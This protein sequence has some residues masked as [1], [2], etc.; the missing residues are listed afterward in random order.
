MDFMKYRI[1]NMEAFK[2]GNVLG[3]KFLKPGEILE[4]SEQDMVKIVNSGGIV[5]VIETM[6]PN[7]KKISQIA[8]EVLEEME[9]K[10]TEAE[11]AKEAEDAQAKEKL[12]RAPVN[13]TPKKRPGR[14]RKVTNAS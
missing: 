2:D 1:K 3:G 4:V 14:P 13:E 8:A 10:K 12:Y 7:P 5:E 11:A 6:I 9:S